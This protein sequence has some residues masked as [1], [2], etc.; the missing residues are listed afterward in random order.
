ME[1]FL[2]IK[3]CVGVVNVDSVILSRDKF[4]DNCCWQSLSCRECERELGRFYVSCCR[5]KMHLN[6]SYI[7]EK[8]RVYQSPVEK[9][10]ETVEREKRVEAIQKPEQ[11][12]RVIKAY[13]EIIG[14]LQ[15]IV[16]NLEDTYSFMYSR[17]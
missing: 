8:D 13:K 11:V 14:D 2:Q 16:N 17:K 1:Q 7:V 15:S 12:E 9:K 6:G 10:R 3:Y 5:E 4:D